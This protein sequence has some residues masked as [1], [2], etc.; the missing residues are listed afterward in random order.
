MIAHYATVLEMT[1]VKGLPLIETSTQKD[2]SRLMIK[3]KWATH[4]SNSDRE[5]YLRSLNIPD[6]SIVNESPWSLFNS[7]KE[8]QEKI[9]SSLFSTIKYDGDCQ[10]MD[11]PA[12][13]EKYY[14]ELKGCPFDKR[15]KGYYDNRRLVPINI[16]SLKPDS[17]IQE[18]DELFTEQNCSLPKDSEILK[19]DLQILKDL[20]SKQYDAR[21]F[22]FDGKKYKLKDIP[23]LIHQLENEDAV[24]QA[25]INALDAEILKHALSLSDP[26]GQNVLIDLYKHYFDVV[27]DTET[28][29]TSFLYISDEIGPMYKGGMS[30]DK[31]RDIVNTVRSIERGIITQIKSVLVEARQQ[32]YLSMMQLDKIEHYLSSNRAYFNGTSFN[33]TELEIFSEAMSLYLSMMLEREYQ[34]KKAML[35]KQIEVFS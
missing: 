35:E 2:K 19:S 12:F 4:P 26:M 3:N 20:Q 9:T 18:F 33:S 23:A 31:A 15:Y 13:K 24:V 6:T 22:D 34:V 1:L 7:P 5:L 30:F 29:V 14:S 27:K 16:D 28:S 21:T 25:K 17:K 10:L 11:L 32:K 8:L